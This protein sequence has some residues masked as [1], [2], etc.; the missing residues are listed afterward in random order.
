MSND[1]VPLLQAMAS[2][3][4]QIILLTTLPQG[5]LSPLE[6]QRFVAL[7]QHP[8]FQALFQ[9]LLQLG[10]N[11]AQ[12]LHQEYLHPDRPFHRLHAIRQQLEQDLPAQQCL[13]FKQQL[14]AFGET[15][16]LM[17]HLPHELRAGLHQHTGA[18]LLE[19]LHQM[20]FDD[21]P[22]LGL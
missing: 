2:A 8:S 1:D 18:I 19:G 3:P 20:L 21:A 12:W 16:I 14:M 5:E 7:S 15:L 10:G 11:A 4:L 13:L 22:P 9:P 17:E 6:R